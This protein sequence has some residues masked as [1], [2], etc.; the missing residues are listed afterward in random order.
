MKKTTKKRKPTDCTMA[1]VRAA[2]KKI[3]ELNKRLNKLE[4]YAKSIELRTEVYGYIIKD[5]AKHVG[6][7]I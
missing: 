1:N 2:N 4:R 6:Y 7:K 5:V 3:A